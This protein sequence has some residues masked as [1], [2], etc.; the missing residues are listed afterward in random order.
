MAGRR[1]WTWKD[2]G[3][4]LYSSVVEPQ[5][6]SGPA[7]PRYGRWRISGDSFDQQP[8]RGLLIIIACLQSLQKR[9]GNHIASPEALSAGSFTLK[10]SILENGSIGAAHIGLISGTRSRSTPRALVVNSRD[11]RGEMEWCADDVLRKPIVA[12]R[13]AAS[14]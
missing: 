2:D 7:I 12:A 6:F 14:R 4:G 13:S 10:T 1:S 8:C 9:T 3:R 5:F 11:R